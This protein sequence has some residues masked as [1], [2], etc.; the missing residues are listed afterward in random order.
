MACYGTPKGFD[1]F[2][3][4]AEYE[5]KRDASQDEHAAGIAGRENTGLA[6]ARINTAG[7]SAVGCGLREKNGRGA[8]SDTFVI[9]RNPS[10]LVNRKSLGR[11]D[12]D[13]GVSGVRRALYNEKMLSRGELRDLNPSG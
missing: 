11:T 8:P 5:I 12:Q 10:T 1:C 2:R 7:S 3:C 6:R 13:R 4:A 9:G